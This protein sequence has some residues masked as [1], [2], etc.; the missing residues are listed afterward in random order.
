MNGNSSTGA[1]IA[2]GALG[3]GEGWDG[4]FSGKPPLQ[5]RF[6]FALTNYRTV[7]SGGI[8]PGLQDAYVSATAMSTLHQAAG[9]SLS[10]AALAL[11]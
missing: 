5:T 2:T 9:S 3:N 7:L 11:S 10:D 8:A 6:A 4:H 1:E